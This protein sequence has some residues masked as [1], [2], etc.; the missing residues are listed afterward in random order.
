MAPLN[1][2]SNEFWIQA[3]GYNSS[4]HPFIGL[5][6]EEIPIVPSNR[7]AWRSSGQYVPLRTRLC[8]LD[9]RQP[10]RIHMEP[11]RLGLIGGSTGG[12]IGGSHTGI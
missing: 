9:H 7:G 2:V 1:I 12:L 11:N 3:S 6:Y 5:T 8:L 10:L 4:Y